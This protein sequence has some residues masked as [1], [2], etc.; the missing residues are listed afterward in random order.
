MVPPSASLWSKT[1]TRPKD[2]VIFETSTKSIPAVPLK[3]R[4]TA[5]LIRLQQA[6]CSHA[7]VTGRFYS[8]RGGFFLPTQELQTLGSALPAHTSRRLSEKHSRS[9]L[10][11]SFYGVPMNLY[12][13]RY[14]ITI[15]QPG[16]SRKISMFFGKAPPSGLPAAAGGP[17]ALCDQSLLRW[18]LPLMVLG[19]SSRKTTMRGYL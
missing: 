5:P 2:T 1:K 4:Q 6:L 16:R 3:L 17:A 15:P 13:V 14:H 7:A 19:S 12:S 18:I 8:R 9:P 10:R 11:H